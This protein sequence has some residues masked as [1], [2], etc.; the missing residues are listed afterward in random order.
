MKSNI[1]YKQLKKPTQKER[2][3]D[4]NML[5]DHNTALAYESCISKTFKAPSQN[6]SINIRWE[7]IKET[8]HNAANKTLIR[9]TLDPKNPLINEQILKDI[10]E[11]RKYKNSKDNQGIKKYK[12]LKNKIKRNAKEAREKWLEDRCHEVELL[13]KK[14]KMD[15]AFNTI[16]KFVSSKTKVN[17]KIRDEN[18]NLLIDNEDIASRW[19]Q[20]LEVLY[21]GEEITS[22][23]NESNPN[24]EGAPILREEF[25]QVLKMMKTRK[26][27]G[28]DNVSTELIQNAGTKIHNKLF[29]LVNDI[30]I[31]GKIP[32]DLKKNIIITFSKKATAE[33]CNEY[34]TLSLM[35]HS[36]KILVKIIGNR[37]EHKI[38]RQLSNDQFGFRRNKGTREAI[39]S[40][41]TLIEKQIE[42]NNDTFMAFIDLEKA[43]DT[44][45]WKELFKTLEEIGIDYKDRQLIYNMY[46]EQL[47]IK[48][49]SDNSAIAKIGKGV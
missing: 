13:L 46:K 24:N 28:V 18:G 23:H 35:I 29:K 21:Q 19:K 12:E 10:E 43:F 8:I 15:Q 5:K 26:S 1:T 33:K 27:P 4:V 2:R 20:Y 9:N 49:V 11:R 45:P 47:A 34:R 22:L 42:F 39:L 48:K 38:E 17:S 3:Y 14:N 44:V 6:H 32:E 31:T 30:Y 37:I 40:L 41:R 16:K 7:A 25:N 36:A